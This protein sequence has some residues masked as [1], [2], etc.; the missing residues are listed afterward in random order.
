M[1]EASSRRIRKLRLALVKGARNLGCANLPSNLLQNCSE[2]ADRHQW[3]ANR[4]PRHMSMYV[5]TSSGFALKFSE[6]HVHYELDESGNHLEQVPCAHCAI[7]RG[8]LQRGGRALD[9]ATHAG[10][11]TFPEAKE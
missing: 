7:W 3:E 6:F 8:Q 10:Q 2:A 4:L 11:V 9:L 1:R 5:I